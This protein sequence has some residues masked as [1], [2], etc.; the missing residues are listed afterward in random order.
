MTAAPCGAPASAPPLFVMQVITKGETGGA[1]T[2]V[3]TLCRALAGR[4]RFT[5]VIGGSDPHPPLARLTA[6]LLKNRLI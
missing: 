1:Q 4:V 6:L 2:H 5:A 3:E